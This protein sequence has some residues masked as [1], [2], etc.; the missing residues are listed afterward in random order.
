MLRTKALLTLAKQPMYLTVTSFLT[1]VV[2]PSSLTIRG[3]FPAVYWANLMREK[4]DA[5]SWQNVDILKVYRIFPA[6]KWHCSVKQDTLT[7]SSQYGE[8]FDDVTVDNAE[9]SLAFKFY[10]WSVVTEIK[11]FNSTDFLSDASVAS[12]Y[13]W[14]TIVKFQERFCN[15]KA[16]I[17]VVCVVQHVWQ[18]RFV[19]QI[20]RWG[21]MM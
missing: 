19:L 5:T 16:H 8:P 17:L 3:F 12:V 11:G 2:H 9:E 13:A 14:A 18:T 6:P 21:C 4:E 7:N 10:N 20:G 1:K 15:F